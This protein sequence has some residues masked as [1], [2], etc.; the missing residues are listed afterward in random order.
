MSLAAAFDSRAVRCPQQ[1]LLRDVPVAPG[2]A[3]ES[4]A[5]QG[6]DRNV[7][8]TQ[9]IGSSRLQELAGVVL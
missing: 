3:A 1:G 4:S 6:H 5:I 9:A 2:I 8:V 7:I